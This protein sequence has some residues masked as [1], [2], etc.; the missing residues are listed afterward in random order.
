MNKIKFIGVLISFFVAANFSFVSATISKTYKDKRIKNYLKK[1]EDKKED[2]K[3]EKKEEKKEDKKK[4]ENP[5]KIV[6]EENPN[7]I[8]EEERNENLTKEQIKAE[9]KKKKEEQ[10][11]KK[12]EEQEKKRKEELKK[13]EREWEEFVKKNSKEVREREKIIAEKEKKGKYKYKYNNI[14][15]DIIND[16][17]NQKKDNILKNSKDNVCVISFLGEYRDESTTSRNDFISV[18]IENFFCK[19][20]FYEL[21]LKELDPKIL[22]KEPHPFLPNIYI[23]APITGDEYVLNYWDNYEDADLQKIMSSFLGDIMELYLKHSDNMV[24]DIELRRQFDNYVSG[25]LEKIKFLVIEKVNKNLKDFED[26]KNKIFNK[27]SK[28]II[29]KIDIIKYIDS[30]IDSEE[31]IDSDENYLAFKYYEKFLSEL[32]KL[33][34]KTLELKLPRLKIPRPKT[35]KTK[36]SNFK[37]SELEFLESETPKLELLEFE[38]PELK[39]S[40][41]KTDISVKNC[42]LGIENIELDFDFPIG[43]FKQNNFGILYDFFIDK[44]KEIDIKSNKLKQDIL[45]SKDKAG[46]VSFLFS[47][48]NPDKTSKISENNFN[49]IKDFFYKCLLYELLVKKVGP[50]IFSEGRY[51]HVPNVYVISPITGEKKVLKYWDWDAFKN[52]WE[53]SDCYYYYILQALYKFS[54]KIIDMNYIL[55]GTA[56]KK[57]YESFQNMVCGHT[58]ADIFKYPFNLV[59]NEAIIFLFHDIKFQLADIVLFYNEKEWYKKTKHE[60][61]EK[62]SNSIIDT[63]KNEPRISLIDGRSFNNKLFVSS[64]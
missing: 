51:K 41:L 56:T 24:K 15:V 26:K 52:E 53:N 7:K 46:V 47:P 18:F 9:K 27:F 1:E 6:E 13:I 17:P 57:G 34:S 28:L 21:L 60:I 25:L 44:I 14:I 54:K 30:D 63:I 2:K 20:L 22:G 45:N 43:Q 16:I 12:K 29:D 32:K 64:L 33:N 62:F 61:F 38:I 48:P 19:Y 11:K 37:M 5:N 3:E 10:E 58:I 59:F 36:K 35:P 23:V 42:I 8:V 39:E 55:T 4:K 31:R 40:E 49:L 50:N